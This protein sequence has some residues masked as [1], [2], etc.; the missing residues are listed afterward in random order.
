MK[1]IK[2]SLLALAVVAG[3]AIGASAASTSEGVTFQAAI[4]FA[5]NAPLSFISVSD[6]ALGAVS[7]AISNANFAGVVDTDA[8]GKIEGSGFTRLL[9]APYI[10]VIN[11]N[12]PASTN[13]LASGV[14]DYNTTVT[15]KVS[16]KNNLPNVQETVK[17]T[18]YS[19]S[20]TNAVLVTGNDGTYVFFRNVNSSSSSFNV[21]FTG[22]AA[23]ISSNATLVGNY[24]GTIKPGKTINNGK[25]IQVNEGALLDV[26]PNNLTQIDL[27]IVKFGNK[28]WANVLDANI[29]GSG[30]IS[31]SGKATANFKGFGREAGDSFKLTGQQGNV[32][33]IVVGAT[34]TVAFLNTVDL[35]GKLNGQTV[36]ATGATVV[37]I[38]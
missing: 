27:Q 5:S 12:A 28:F 35:S 38:P 34:N 24:K 13:R 7:L 10:I 4:R 37:Q 1:K 2:V 6:V 15:G 11:T 31:G 16:T 9:F 23:V 3:G 18:G 20:P 8:S 32:I 25:T 21:N 17:G 22:N 33:I 19:S 26:D 29:N 36:S 14:G 30:N